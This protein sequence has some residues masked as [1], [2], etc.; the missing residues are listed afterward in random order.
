MISCA[1][2]RALELDPLVA[3]G[4]HERDGPPVLVEDDQPA[5]ARLER[6]G[7]FLDVIVTEQP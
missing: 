4:G 2:T 5:R 1:V 3:C 7:G 6:L